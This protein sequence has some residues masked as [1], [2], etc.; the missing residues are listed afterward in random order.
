MSGST[1][2]TEWHTDHD[3]HDIHNIDW[4]GW[5]QNDGIIIYHRE[6]GPAYILRYSDPY[7]IKRWGEIISKRYYVNGKL[8]RLDGPAI[9]N[10]AH[11]DYEFYFVYGIPISK[12]D[13]DKI[14]IPGFLD[15]FVLENS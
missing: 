12:E 3:E 1:P 13:F 9:K 7:Y 8:H 11:N 2:K 4:H 6:S 14:N 15:A 10:Y 5:V